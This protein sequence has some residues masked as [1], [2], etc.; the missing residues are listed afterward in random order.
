MRS[1][2]PVIL[3]NSRHDKR[4]FTLIELII[5]IAILGILA[6]ITISYFVGYVE[7]AKTKV[8]NINCLQLEKQ[9]NAYLEI[10]EIEHSEVIFT[11]F[12]E[13]YD[14]L[15]PKHGEVGYE[16]GKFKCGIH[17]YDEKDED[18]PYI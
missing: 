3:T 18:V 14:D 2:N 11:K 8:C 15:C 5:V 9:Y 13:E 1:I 17:S 12:V 10:E 7:M 16:E 4:G 6:T